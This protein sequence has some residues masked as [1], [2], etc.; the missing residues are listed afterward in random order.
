MNKYWIAGIVADAYHEEG[1]IP[2]KEF[3]IRLGSGGRIYWN[4]TGY[5]R[6]DRKIRR[7]LEGRITDAIEVYIPRPCPMRVFYRVLDTFAL[8]SAWGWIEP[9]DHFSSHPLIRR[10]ERLL[11]TRWMNAVCGVEQE[12][13][14]AGWYDLLISQVVPKAG[15]F[16]EWKRIN[17]VHGYKNEPCDDIVKEVAR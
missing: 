13:D 10:M 6:V 12:L 2:P 7:A 14:V 16:P 8:W 3:S 4:N 1:R 15:A 17:V 11:Y 5:A 9:L